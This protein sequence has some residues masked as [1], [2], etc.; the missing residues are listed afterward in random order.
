MQQTLARPRIPRALK[1]APEQAERENSRT[2]IAR[3]LGQVEALSRALDGVGEIPRVASAQAHPAQHLGVSGGHGFVAKPRQRDFA[4]AH[5][6]NHRSGAI[7]EIAKHVRRRGDVSAG[8]LHFCRIE[9]SLRKSECLLRE[10]EAYRQ[11]I[12]S[13]R[14]REQRG[15]VGRHA[16]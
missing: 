16:V 6:P 11:L 3:E 9:C 2:L 5:N 12:A 13:V 10:R 14:L 8:V 4:Q 1:A 15:D 7:Q